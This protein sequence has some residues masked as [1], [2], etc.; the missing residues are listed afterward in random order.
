ME[1]WIVHVRIGQFKISLETNYQQFRLLLL[2]NL[3][4]QPNS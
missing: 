3:R 1:E 4:M 2:R